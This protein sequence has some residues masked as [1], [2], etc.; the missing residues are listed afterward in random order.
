MHRPY[1]ASV[2]DEEEKEDLQYSGFTGGKLVHESLVECGVTHVFGA[3][4]ARD[5]Q[6]SLNR[7][8]P[9]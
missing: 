6:P 4:R 9:P 7:A 2:I 8:L 5:W 1:R 3:L